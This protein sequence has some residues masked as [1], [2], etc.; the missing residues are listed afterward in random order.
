MKTKFTPAERAEEYLKRIAALTGAR[1]DDDGAY[2]LTTGSIR[3]LVGYKF[4]RVMSRR[5]ESTCFS[6][7][8]DPD[9]PR[10]EMIASALLQLKN[11]P[12]L[13]KKW[14][15]RQG[16]EFKA[17]GQLFGDTYQLTR[18]EAETL[19]R[20]LYLSAVQRGL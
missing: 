9:L 15:E 8:A 10:A 11:N 17:N 6:V 13:F 16:D 19:L 2:R 18:D 4:V 14:R 12:R 3:F 1:Q 7:A 20:R 5:D